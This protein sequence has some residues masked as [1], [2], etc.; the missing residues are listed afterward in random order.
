MQHT[1]H[2]RRLVALVAGAVCVAGGITAVNAQAAAGCRVTYAINSQWPGGFGVNVTVDN[3]GDAISAWQ[4]TWAFTAG[5][6]ITQLWNGT[7]SQSGSQVTVK[8]AG[9]N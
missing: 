3:L 1:R 8:D 6:T 4:L 7:V 2:R 5:Q 9:W